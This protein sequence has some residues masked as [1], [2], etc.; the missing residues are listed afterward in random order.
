MAR[1]KIIYIL[2]IKVNKLFSLFVLVYTKRNR[3]HVVRV[4]LSYTT[5][6]EVWE[7]SKK[8]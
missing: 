4:L 6:V 7:N 1:A 5:L 2:M 3:K 8:L